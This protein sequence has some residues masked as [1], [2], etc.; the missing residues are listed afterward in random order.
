MLL[1][2]GGDTF[3]IDTFG[4]DTLRDRILAKSGGLMISGCTFVGSYLDKV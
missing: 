3:G 2:L 4:I 1:F